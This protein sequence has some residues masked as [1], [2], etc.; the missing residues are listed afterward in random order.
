MT[1]LRDRLQ[2][3]LGAAYSLEHELGGGGMSRVF[4]ATETS[5]GR[6]VVVKVLPPDLGGDVNIDRF[7]REVRLAARL[8]HPHI[9]PVLT[10]GE[11]DGIPYYTMP[12]VE[13]Q[14]L[15]ARLVDSGALPLAEVIGILGD[16][17]KALAYAHAHGVVHR[18]IKPDN[19]LLS[20]G[21]AVV[22]DFGIA[23]ALSEA[24]APSRTSL[25]GTGTSIGT[26]AYMAPEQAAA[27][28]ATD[29]RAD[30]Y[31]FGCMAYEMLTGQPPF[32]AWPAQKRLVAQITETPV[33]LA[34]FRPDVPRA[35]DLLVM[36]C[37]EKDPAHRPQ[38]AGELTRGLEAVAARHSEQMAMPATL[39]VPVVLG[40]AMALYVAA[41]VAVMLLTRGAIAAIGLPD[42]VLGGAMIV[43]ALGLPV[44]L[45]TGWVHYVT[46][47]AASE[48]PG[49]ASPGPRA[50]RRSM[51]ALVER[52]SPHVSWSRTVRGGLLAF[53]LFVL[54][55]SG[56]MTLRALGIGPAGSLLAAGT[57]KERDRLLVGDFRISGGDSSL[58]RVV[59]EAVRTGLGESPLF[60][61]VTPTAIAGAL[62]RMQREPTTWVDLDLAREIAVR[63][64]AKAV[65]T[66]D[67]N[68]LGGGYVVTLRLVSA[69]SGAELA[70]FHETADSPR[71]LLPT[72]DKLTRDL[73]G[74][75]GESLRNVRADPPLEQVTTSS[76]HALRLYV[77]GA[78][79]SDAGEHETAIKALEAAIAVDTTFA[80]AHRKLTA[81]YTNAGYPRAMRDAPLRKAYRYRDRL[82]LRERGQL[83]GDYFTR[84]PGMDRGQGIAAYEALLARYPDDAVGTNNLANAYETRREFARAESLFALLRS[85]DPKVLLYHTNLLGTLTEQRKFDQADSV[86]E[87]LRRQFPNRNSYAFYIAVMLYNRGEADSALSLMRLVRQSRSPA[88]RALGL[89]F[90]AGATLS[91]GRLREMSALRAE[92]SAVNA[93]RGATTPALDDSLALS[94]LD[95][96]FREQPARGIQRMEAALRQT[97]LRSLASG[98]EPYYT[99]TPGYSASTPYF[100][101]ATQY[102]L[103][104]RA[105]KAR[106]VLAQ[107]DADVRDTLLRRLLEPGRQNALGEIALAEQR[108]RDAIAAFRRGDSRSDGPATAC[109]GCP[110]VRLGRAFD[111][112]GDPDSAIVM[113]EQYLVSAGPWR[114]GMDGDGSHLA[115]IYKR[116]G[117]LH[118]AK[119][120]RVKA[121]SYYR[122]FV[123]LWKTADPELQPKV[124]EVQRRLARMGNPDG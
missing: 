82:T 89:N 93:A 110:L 94:F 100:T 53:G 106:A 21:V 57:L 88:E 60:T 7:R 86:A 42:W 25:T 80:M 120:D 95:I 115:G 36:K 98:G 112:A 67:I 59:T 62:R 5:L 1:E 52:A 44:V 51:T 75:A 121:A 23:K 78:R 39:L 107:Y 81:A 48:A 61:M 79:A 65:V 72:I 96:W 84:G 101:V 40:K 87:V 109:G 10:A 13:G 30:L 102:A 15:R 56:F 116:L 105:D 66:G 50:S 17:A 74:K 118:E 18:D 29:H 69:D 26:P 108:P 117:E 63:E 45:L 3:S 54:F 103:A 34:Q 12:F 123:A 73:R 97:P 90:L 124:A 4:V 16:V 70:S 76:L 37:L 32:A 2:G 91:R 104:N 43:M 20:G 122:R 38:S 28:P 113:F 119:G 68:P 111:R 9:V 47:R 49:A 31:A 114:M 14:S 64:G 22:T 19:V 83:V 58:A 24:T 6:S 99:I 8:Q 41:A 77:E 85:T 71:E 46:R 92:R 11:M 33:Q 27:D 55:V 35:L